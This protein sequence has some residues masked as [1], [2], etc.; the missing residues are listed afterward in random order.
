MKTYQ[1]SHSSGML[2]RR[3]KFAKMI[4]EGYERCQIRAVEGEEERR[5][6]KREGRR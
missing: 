2:R 5:C 4:G 6:A 3:K 1:A